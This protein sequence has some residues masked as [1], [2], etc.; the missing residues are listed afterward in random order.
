MAD[1][2]GVRR[3]CTL[4]SPL[5]PPPAHQTCRFFYCLYKFQ[6]SHNDRMAYSYSI[7]SICYSI[8]LQYVLAY[9]GHYEKQL[10]VFSVFRLKVWTSFQNFLDPLLL[11][12]HIV[13]E[14]HILDNGFYGK[15]WK[16]ILIFVSFPIRSYN[17]SINQAEIQQK[18]S[19]AQLKEIF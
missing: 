13:A 19:C 7:W 18:V 14:F 5:P 17:P 3:L 2:D 6:N 15:W 10:K 9:L 11:P 8:I 12:I 1:P 16:L 4:P